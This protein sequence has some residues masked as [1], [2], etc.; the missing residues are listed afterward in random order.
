MFTGLVQALGRVDALTPTPTGVRLLIDPAGWNHRPGVGD[1]IA[2][3]GACMTVAHIDAGPTGPRWAFDVI[4]ESLAKTTL[5]RLRPGA[6]VNLEH[7]VS[8]STLMGGHFVQ[9]HVDGVGTVTRVQDGD[10]W[11]LTVRPPAHVREAMIPKGSVCLAGVSLTIASIDAD[12]LTVAL[13]PT[14]LAK[15]NLAGLRAGDEINVEADML[16]KAVVQ[17]TRAVLAQRAGT[18]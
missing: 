5:G 15:T 13:I 16:V 6:R 12:T 18:P 14:T 9:G 8:A 4:H 17:V 7:A 3:D 2:I 11:R 10:D 1:S